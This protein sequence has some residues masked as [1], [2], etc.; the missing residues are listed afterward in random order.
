MPG[1][2][3]L[4]QRP[5]FRKKLN[6]TVSERDVSMAE[7]IVEKEELLLWEYLIFRRLKTVKGS[8]CCGASG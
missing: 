7:V 1:G 4:E 3:T 5:C 6:H 8:S 2:R